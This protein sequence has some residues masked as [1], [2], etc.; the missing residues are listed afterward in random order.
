MYPALATKI[1]N[2]CFDQDILSNLNVFIVFIFCYTAGA[3][4]LHISSINGALNEEVFLAIFNS[5]KYVVCTI[6][7]LI[8]KLFQIYLNLLK[9]S[10][11]KLTYDFTP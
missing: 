8:A 2:C 11:Q 10:Q 4:K 5:P 7:C 3:S 1:T 9:M 6:K